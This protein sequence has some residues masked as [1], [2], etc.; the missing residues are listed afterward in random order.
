MSDQTVISDQFHHLKLYVRMPA[1][2]EHLSI[3]M[4]GADVP[5][6]GLMEKTLK[7][8]SGQQDPTE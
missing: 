1:S 3:I 4:N 8:K 6:G 2:V 7:W 5:G